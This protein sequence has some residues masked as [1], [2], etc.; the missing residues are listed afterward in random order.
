MKWPLMSSEEIHAFG[1]DVIIP[2]V[3]K[4]G[5]EIKGVSRD[6]SMIPQIVGERWGSLAYIYVQTA[7][8]PDKGKLSEEDFM[9]YMDWANTHQATP[10]FAS[11]GIA[12][13]HYPD[14]TEVET[15]ED[16]RLPIRNGG[17]AVAY[18]GLLVMASSDRV[19]VWDEDGRLRNVDSPGQVKP[20]GDE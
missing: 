1:I 17:F 12:C 16:M 7:V 9:L 5:V 6:P 10:F 4:E 18:E 3:Q 20:G 8:Y 15:D 11:V 14:K 2:C 13:M 19:K